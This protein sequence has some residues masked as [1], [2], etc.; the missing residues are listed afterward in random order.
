MKK[1][2]RSCS[3]GVINLIGITTGVWTI[4]A[5]CAI[6]D[7]YKTH[8]EYLRSHPLNELTGVCY[9]IKEHPAI[10]VVGENHIY[11]KA[12]SAWAEGVA[13]DL[14]VLLMEGTEPSK[15]S[16]NGHTVKEY[17][18]GVVY[19]PGSLA[20]Q[21][22]LGRENRNRRFIDY[23]DANKIKYLESNTNKSES[24]GLESL[25]TLEQAQ[26]FV[27]L[28]GSAI[29]AP[30]TY[31]RLRNTV[32]K[33]EKRSLDCSLRDSAKSDNREKD[34]IQ[35]INAILQNAD[36]T[37]TYGIVVGACHLEAIEAALL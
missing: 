23:V 6:Y 32:K 26:L 5:G 3:K 16:N 28:S 24:S 37:M 34:M 33:E 11:T 27:V 21:A 9:D 2:L 7:F 31:F 30:Y 17:I 14:D 4:A 15:N 25:D 29:A 1:I 10:V 12:E 20:V 36:S 13:S 8:A 19:E 18:F 35:N 22:A